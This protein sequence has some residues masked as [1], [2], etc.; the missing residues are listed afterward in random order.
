[1][2]KKLTVLAAAH[3]LE[4]FTIAQLAS[5]AGVG[6]PTVHTVLGR[7]PD[8]WFTK[9]LLQS[10]TR[11]G[12][13]VQYR[14]SEEGRN[15][16]VKALQ[17]VSVLPSLAPEHPLSDEPLG[18][19]LA[20]TAIEKLAASPP[21]SA[22]GWVE[23]ALGNL[24]WAEAEVRE[25]AYAEEA[26]YIQARIDTLR[27]V[28][29]TYELSLPE[30]RLSRANLRMVPGRAFGTH[31]SLEAPVADGWS[32]LVALQATRAVTPFR[33]HRVFISHTGDVEAQVLA[34]FAK[35]ALTHAHSESG[36][37]FDVVVRHLFEG[38]RYAEALQR[39]TEEISASAEFVLCVNSKTNASAMWKVLEAMVGSQALRSAVVL[40]HS[41]NSDAQK[42]AMRHHIS[43]EPNA[44]ESRDVNWVHNTI[45]GF[46]DSH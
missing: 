29:E 7:V 21:E 6:A 39:L 27:S 22:Q 11:G 43:Y 8:G 42:Y 40:D 19:T 3:A 26:Q 2:S 41:S 35:G 31:H 5:K 23:D 24:E 14:L 15:E 18:L 45:H 30:V 20:R 12:Q 32:R 4:S 38:G 1:M 37:P 10:G 25:G 46:Q 9:T 17:A 34:G 44:A 36:H 28:A 33:A 16:I 13:P